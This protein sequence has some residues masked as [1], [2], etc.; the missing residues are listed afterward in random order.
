MRNNGLLVDGIVV[1]V[2]NEISE[3]YNSKKIIYLVEIKGLI[4]RSN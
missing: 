3:R 1:I 2:T 4:K